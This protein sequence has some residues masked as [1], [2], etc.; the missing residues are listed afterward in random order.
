M[1]SITAFIRTS[2][3]RADKVNV[4]FR[5]SDGR[6]IQLFHKSEIEVDPELFDKK[7][8]EIK[9]KVIYPEKEKTEFNNAVAERKKL[10]RQIYNSSQNLT[11]EQLDLLIDKEL[12]P[13]KYI[14]EDVEQK[15]QSYFEIFDQFL[16]LHKISD[17]RKAHYRVLKRALQRYELYRGITLNMDTIS[18]DTIIDIEAFLKDEKSVYKEFPKIYELIPES[19]TPQPRGINTIS[20]MLSK[21]R[22]FCLWLIEEEITKNNPFKSFSIDQEVYGT[23]FYISIEE[24]NKLYN[25]D[26]SNRPEL[27]IQRDIFIFH[28][29]IGCR[30]SDLYRLTKSSVINGGVEYIAGKTKE[31]NPVTV[32][33]PLNA[34]AKEILKKYAVIEGKRLLPFI[35]KDKYNDAIKK[36]FAVAGLTRMVTILNSATREEEKRPLNEIASSHLARRCFIGNLYK[37]VKDPNLVGSLSGHKEGSKAFARYREI[38]EE[39][40][41]DLVKMLE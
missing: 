2:A 25:F 38:D 27:A 11:S 29:L 13:E 41:I 30:I 9:A 3:K 21:Y 18:K 1:A 7:K 20:G 10:I 19:R 4:R 15:R 34:T 8:Q 32:R 39:M 5:L 12:H 28:C 33:V 35:S 14:T 24:R 23:P 16:K 37:K 17:G 26:L 40:K 31:G 6:D 36:M 22:T